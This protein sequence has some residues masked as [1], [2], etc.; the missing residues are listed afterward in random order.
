[1]KT[2]WIFVLVCLCTWMVAAKAAAVST[3]TQDTMVVAKS[4]NDH[5]EP[6]TTLSKEETSTAEPVPPVKLT[7]MEVTSNIALRYAHTAVVTRVRNPAKRAQETT[8]KILLPETAFI[9]GFIMTLDGK[10]YKAY[11][12]EKEEAK[13]IYNQAVA[14]GAGA[15]HIAAKARDSNQFTVTV[16]VE[17]NTEAVFNLTYEELL[18]RRNGVYNHAI[19][20]HPGS[21]VPNL[22]VTVNIHESQKITVLRVPEVRTGNE[23]DATAEDTQNSKAVIHHD[24]RVATVTFKPDL[25]EQ[26]RLIGIYMEKSKES[27][28]N[29]ERNLIYNRVEEPEEQESKDGIL[30][31]FV[32][33]YDVDRPKNGEIIVNNGYFVHFFAPA[34][35]PPLNKHVV[36]VL[37]TS[38]SM[39]DRKI[40]QLQEAM[41]TILSD[42]NKGDYFNIVEFDSSV[43]VH[44]LKEADE[45]PKVPDYRYFRMSNTPK[46]KLVP[47]SLAT[48]ENIAK[49]KVIVN[50]LQAAGGTNIAQALDIAVQIVKKG[51]SNVTTD[52][53][54]ENNP[55]IQSDTVSANETETT[56]LPTEQPPTETKPDNEAINLEPIIIF[57]TDGDPTVGETNPTRIIN[58]LT[59]KNYGANKATIF[60]LAFGQDADRKFL[61]KISLRNDGFM[62]HIYEAADAA[63]QLRDFYRQVSSPLLAHVKFVYPP[64]QVKNDMITKHSFRTY[65]EG[66]E[67]VVAGR[68]DDSAAEITSQVHAFCGNEGESGKI[69]YDVTLKAPVPQTKNYYLPLERLWAYLTVK[70]LLDEKDAQLDTEQSKDK[71]KSPEKKALNIALKYELV[72]PL[73]SLVVVKPNATKDAVNAESVDKVDSV[74]NGFPGAPLSALYSSSLP[75]AHYQGSVP[76]AQASFESFPQPGLRLNAPLTRDTGVVEK[77]V[78]TTTT[79][80][81]ADQLQYDDVETAEYAL[82]EQPVVGFDTPDDMARPRPTQYAYMQVAQVAHPTTPFI[83]PLQRYHLEAYPWALTLINITTDSLLVEVNGTTLNMKLST[84]NTIPKSPGGDPVCNNAIDN[85]TGVCVYLLNCVAAQSIT[86]EKYVHSACVVDTGYAGVC[87]PNVPDNVNKPV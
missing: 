12:K 80:H 53:I 11:V 55:D 43:T 63:Q 83:D 50:R 47:P 35:L 61:R 9:S 78:D 73:T 32:V 39:S 75:L 20:L 33:Q 74:Q 70:Q 26:K 65:Y 37:D 1:M 68:V 51:L 23:I 4:E 15:A 86:V 77:R 13:N 56:I 81:V 66:S 76:I 2:R 22:S 69:P 48:P 8:F 19:N 27:Q 49:A 14:S 34:D 31:Q 21:L 5:T 52:N 58:R 7:E 59:E 45:E 87:C 64:D 25:E 18:V 67:V 44:E 85:T 60:S 72:T 57:L 62:R 24:D 41:Q 82:E 10:S 40:V 29:M 54:V 3:Q 84:D 71:E 17:P 28:A 36:F 30:G 42:L 6:S 79:A 38:G 46:V 16:N